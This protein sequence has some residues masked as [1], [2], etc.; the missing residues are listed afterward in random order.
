MSDENDFFVGYLGMPKKD[1]RFLLKA[2]PLGLLGVAGAGLGLGLTA[3]SNGGGRWE[4]GT[5]VTLIGRIGFHPYPVLWSGGKGIVL[6]GVAKKSAD[7]YLRPF[8]G[9]TVEVSGIKITRKDCFM[10]GI[11]EG[12]I[13]SISQDLPPLPQTQVLGEVSLMGEILDARNALYSRRIACLF[14]RRC[15]RL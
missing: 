3:P 1:R 13:K 7:S 14:L 4:T 15:W 8:D 2:V 11:A 9:K 5:P 10:L 6:S 12:D